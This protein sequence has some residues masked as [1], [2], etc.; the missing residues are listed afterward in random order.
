MN[1]RLGVGALAGMA[2][3][4]GACE[5]A[6]A[7][8]G[9]PGSTLV[10]ERVVGIVISDEGFPVPEP[11]DQI[12]AFDGELLVGRFVFEA[13]GGDGGDGG[14]Q[15]GGEALGD[16][17][18]SILV[19]GDNPSTEDRDGA[20]Q[21]AVITFKFFDSGT[22]VITNMRTQNNQGERA[23]YRYR[24]VEAPP[25][26]ILPID[27]TPT[28]SFNL[29]LTDS[30]GD[31]GGGG[32]GEGGEGYDVNGDGVINDKDVVIVLRAISGAQITM[33]DGEL[34]AADVNDDGLV[35]TQ[36]AIAIM[37]NK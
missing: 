33:S 16:N 32:G 11:G 24:G 35:N 20:R 17:E 34:A 26:D 4:M 9:V 1:G 10:R 5:C 13:G 27:L 23:V 14:D 8:F 19:Y 31:G 3:L 28:R 2:I 6:V 15:P 29:R 7:Q 18:F 30:A 25:I 12:G 37:R 21:E 22:E 36:D